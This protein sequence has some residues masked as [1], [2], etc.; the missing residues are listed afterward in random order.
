MSPLTARRVRTSA[1][2]FPNDTRRL[3]VHPQAPESH[4]YTVGIV[5]PHG[6]ELVHASFPTSAAGYLDGIELLT[7]HGVDRIGIEGSA[8]WGAHAAIAFVAAGF[9]C[10]EIPGSQKISVSQPRGRYVDGG[11]VDL[12]T[13]EMF[14]SE[15]LLRQFV[16]ERMLAGVAT[17]RHVDVAEPVG[18]AWC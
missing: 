15:N 11:E 10:C 2:S 9:E 8:A 18:V 17:R 5:D 6:V 14:A 7:T 16:V 13:W 12:A 1:R 4:T 3:F